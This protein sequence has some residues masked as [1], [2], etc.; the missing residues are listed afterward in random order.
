MFLYNLQSVVFKNTH[1]TFDQ[2]FFIQIRFKCETLFLFF[3]VFLIGTM[4]RK[5][6]FKEKQNFFRCRRRKGEDTL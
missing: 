6:L 4:V 2:G 3:L 1:Q 5:K